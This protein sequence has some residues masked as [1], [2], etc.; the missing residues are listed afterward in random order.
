[1]AMITIVFGD[2][3]FVL[4]IVAFYVTGSQHYTALIPAVAGM[5]FNILGIVALNPGRRKHAMHAAA[6]LALIGCLGT[7]T[8]VVKT[9]RRLSGAQVER[10][11]AA[12]SQA[13]MCVLCLVFVLLCVRSFMVARANRSPELS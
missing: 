2:L 12:Y 13:I 3:L 10:E 6:A 8:G 9:I 5:F 4:G 11:A 1:M 7:V